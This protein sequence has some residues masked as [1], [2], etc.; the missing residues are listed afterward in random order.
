MNFT[1]GFETG[2]DGYYGR[3][4]HMSRKKSLKKSLRES[5]RKLRKGRSQRIKTNKSGIH[6]D[7]ICAGGT[8]VLPH[9]NFINFG[10]NLKLE[11]ETH[12]ITL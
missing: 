7:P 5:F 8:N 6:S 10:I 1:P 4:G 12:E 11:K 2:W 9:M 3:Q